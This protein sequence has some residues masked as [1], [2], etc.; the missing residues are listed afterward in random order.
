MPKR[1]FAGCARRGRHRDRKQHNTRV[2]IAGQKG[3]SRLLTAKSIPAT[4]RTAR[5]RPLP[6]GISSAH[7]GLNFAL[8][9][10]HGTEVTLVVQPM[11]GDDSP[12]AE[13]AL[14]PRLNRTG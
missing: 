13:I 14:D 8:L 11:D 7:E 9:C 6:L 5:G 2:S 12:I 1:R 10:R 3:A 4:I